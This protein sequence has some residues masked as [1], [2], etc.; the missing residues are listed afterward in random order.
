MDALIPAFVTILLAET[1][2]RVQAS[3]HTL[4]AKFP[5]DG[6]SVFAALFLTTLASLTLAAVGGTLV[7]DIIP[8][9]AR[10]LLAG[11]ALLF[12]GGAML[13]VIRHARAPKGDRSFAASLRTLVPIQFADASQFIVFAIAA[14]SDMPV[15]AT[16]AGLAAVLVAAA[17]PLALKEDWPGAIPL[18]PIRRACGVLL[19]LGGAGL[20]MDA[21][22]LI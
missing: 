9:N 19:I 2:G 7:A 17:V 22:R 10:T 8:F 3:V 14:R 21:L 11:L 20:C 13:F 5:G 16:L 18:T 4:Q 1:G 6:K 15:S 12:A